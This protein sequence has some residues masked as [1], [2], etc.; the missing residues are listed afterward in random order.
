[1]FDHNG[2]MII[3]FFGKRS[4]GEQEREDWRALLSSLPPAPETAV[5]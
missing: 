4:A 1:V 5:A 3:Q 2:E